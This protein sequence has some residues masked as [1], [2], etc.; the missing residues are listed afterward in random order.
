MQLSG[1]GDYDGGA[2][3]VRDGRERVSLPRTRGTLTRSRPGWTLHQVEPV[4]RGERWVLA[5]AGLGPPLR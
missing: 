1:P 4:T 2:L 3:C 5:V